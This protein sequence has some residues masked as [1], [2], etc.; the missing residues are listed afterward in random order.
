[1]PALG[2]L[3]ILAA[4]ASQFTSWK[5]RMLGCCRHSI[6]C[7]RDT[8]PNYRAAWRHGLKIGLRCVW[9]CA[10]LTA[11]L[12]VLGVMDLRMMALLTL[13]IYAERLLPASIRAVHV[14]GTI[15]LLAGVCA[16]LVPI[17]G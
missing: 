17:P 3:V 5:S 2:A 10:P 15:L 16:L 6:D 14:V 12:L 1:V 9:C 7:S 13:A 4:G 8:Q 11:V